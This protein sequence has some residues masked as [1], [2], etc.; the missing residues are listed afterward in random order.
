LRGAEAPASRQQSS[1]SC[2]VWTQ[3][4]TAQHVSSVQDGLD[5]QWQEA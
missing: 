1:I 4:S 5:K 3:H 2:V